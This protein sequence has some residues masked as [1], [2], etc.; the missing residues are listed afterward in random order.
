MKFW[1]TVCKDLNQQ[2]DCT[3]NLGLTFEVSLTS[4]K[5]K[6]AS[7]QSLLIQFPVWIR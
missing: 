4:K 2:T 6:A 7:A 5:K 3:C 1:M